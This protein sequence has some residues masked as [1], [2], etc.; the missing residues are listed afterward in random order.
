MGLDPGPESLEARLFDEK[1][2][3][4]DELAF[5]TVIR[6][7]RWFVADRR[8]G[9]FAIHTDSIVYQPKEKSG[10]VPGEPAPTGTSN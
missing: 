6:T 8:E 2:I 9:N 5:K 1:D 7:L 3:P 10:P 4:W